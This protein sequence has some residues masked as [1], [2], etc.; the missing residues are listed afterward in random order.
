[1][2][3]HFR[4]DFTAITIFDGTA[5]SEEVFKGPLGRNPLVALR[6]PYTFDPTDPSITK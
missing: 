4:Q 5:R 6:A 1:M 2:Y 3:M